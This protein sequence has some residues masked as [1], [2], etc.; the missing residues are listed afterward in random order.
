MK[1]IF[2]VAILACLSSMF[3]GCDNDSQH[4]LAQRDINEKSVKEDTLNRI[5]NSNVSVAALDSLKN[6]VELIRGDM[7]SIKEELELSINNK[8]EELQKEKIGLKGLLIA[9][10]ILFVIITIILFV[11]IKKISI[12]KEGMNSIIENERRRY[13]Q[14]I[15]DKFN[16]NNKEISGHLNNINR[17]AKD[18]ERR[19]EILERTQGRRISTT[20]IPPDNNT[21]KTDSLEKNDN[22]FYMMCPSESGMFGLSLKREVKSEDTFYKFVLDK[23][24]RGK[25]KFWFEPYDEA[26]VNYAY[27]YREDYIEKVCDINDEKTSASGRYECIPGRAELRDNKWVVKQKPLVIFL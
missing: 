16:I 12:S 17:L 11:L 27:T 18:A 7:D 21:S 14:L 24:D 10:L 6:R 26:R 15:E 23:K 2:V 8:V 13:R 19:V 20:P 3:V 1:R 5:E 22:E 9:S 25:A 4:Y